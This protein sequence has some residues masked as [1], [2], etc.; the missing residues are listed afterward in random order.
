MFM[1]NYNDI[2]HSLYIYFHK[3]HCCTK[4]I[5]AAMILFLKLY[6]Y[7]IFLLYLI[8]FEDIKESRKLFI[9]WNG[10]K[11]WKISI[12]LQEFRIPYKQ[13][14]FM[15]TLEEYRLN[16]KTLCINPNEGTAKK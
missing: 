1:K 9:K 16:R 6:Q 5:S 7:Q 10:K 15:R 13:K 2:S 11:F 14:I 3:W 8:K 4:I 12:K